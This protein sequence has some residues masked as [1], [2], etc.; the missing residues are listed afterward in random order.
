MLAPEAA[1]RSVAARANAADIDVLLPVTSTL[2]TAQMLPAPF[3]TMRIFRPLETALH[4]KLAAF[5]LAARHPS[6]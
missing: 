2:V 4:F 5:G 6:S 3:M 1:W